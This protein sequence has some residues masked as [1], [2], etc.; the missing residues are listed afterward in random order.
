MKHITLI[1]AI[2]AVCTLLSP[3]TWAAGA[4]SYEGQIL[5]PNDDPF[6]NSSVDFTVELWNTPGTCLIYKTVINKDMSGSSGMFQLVIGSV[7]PTVYGATDITAAFANGS[8]H[9]CKAPESGIATYNPGPNDRRRIKV[10]F[11]DGTTDVLADDFETVD[12]PSAVT[13]QSVS[14]YRA[15]NLF[16]VSGT[17]ASSFSVT[18]FNAVYDF[19]NKL[20]LNTN[21]SSLPAPT[22]FGDATNF[23]VLEVDALGR[24]TNV[25]LQPIS[26]GSGSIGDGSIITNKIADGAVTTVKLADGAVSTLK[27]GNLQV[28]DAKIASVDAG[29]MTGILSVENGGTGVAVVPGDA[30]KVFAVNAA[31]TGGS[32]RSLIA[33]P[34]IDITHGAGSITIGS[35]NLGTVT[36]VGL[37]MPSFFS[38]GT[39]TI[40]NSGTFAVS[41]VAQ[42][43]NKILA[44]PPSSTG[45]PSF[46]TLTEND[47]PVLSVAGKVL[48]SATSATSVSTPDTIIK[49]DGTNKFFAG[50][51]N[52]T[53]TEFVN[54]GATVSMHASGIPFTSYD[55]FLP[56]SAGTNGQVLRTDGAGTLSW[57][58]PAVGTVTSVNLTTPSILTV[59]G[60]PVSSS[61]TIALALANTQAK[62]FFAGPLHGAG[63]NQP[64]FRVMDPRD[65]P[66]LSGVVVLSA[67]V[68]D[69]VG[70]PYT[71]DGTDEKKTFLLPGSTGEYYFSET[72]P[73][74]SQITI[75]NKVGAFNYT[76]VYM[77]N[78]ASTISTNDSIYMAAGA[79][80]TLV[81]RDANSWEVVTS[82]K[83]GAINCAPSGTY[84]AD[85]VGLPG[86]QTSFCIERTAST[87]TDYDSAT[88]NCFDR[89]RKLCTM[90]ELRYARAKSRVPSCTSTSYNV[91]AQ[92]PV[93]TT[94]ALHYNCNNNSYAAGLSVRASSN[95]YLCCY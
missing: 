30:N 15:E 34:G 72:L 2:L 6:E 58:T 76:R 51:A 37:T 80:V 26:L 50:S 42:T 52:L 10:Y 46:R 40:T 47:I 69:V 63:D 9:T 84:Q 85:L 95:P 77:N 43:Q 87:S 73:V 21:V 25:T 53:T 70:N 27:I 94:E 49:R 57:M 71:I 48:D 89:G 64:T 24:V 16:K 22:T 83:M 17:I 11:Y 74:G 7:A 91:W 56:T 28:T 88:I 60:A 19:A 81:K 61:G 32:V 13:S 5:K 4:L 1:F 90:D 55:L 38:V 3:T 59:S 67:S 93:S 41:M 75:S 18:A 39:P 29:K 86:L 68:G 14:G 82:H 92:N 62:K 79:S 44:S 8:S 20:G 54:G 45:T 65:V 31:G 33:G 36:S 35:Q 66:A 78:T 23:P 12:A